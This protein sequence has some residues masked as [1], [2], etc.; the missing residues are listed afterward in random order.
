MPITRRRRPDPDQPENNNHLS[1]QV[2]SA[3]DSSPNA[4]QPPEAPVDKEN[5]GIPALERTDNV[6]FT[7]TIPPPAPVSN[8][9]RFE[10]QDYTPSI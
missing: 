9:D 10:R 5:V 7:P 4:E 1:D 3:V 2:E 8:G 6:P